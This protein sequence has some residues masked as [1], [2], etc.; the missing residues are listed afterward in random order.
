MKKFLAILLCLFAFSFSMVAIACDKE[1]TNPSN[2]IDEDG[3]LE[4]NY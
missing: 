1:N 2:G 3:W 4:K